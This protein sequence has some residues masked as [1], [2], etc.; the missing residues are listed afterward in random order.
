MEEVKVYELKKKDLTDATVIEGFPSVGL[1]SSIAGNYL[2]NALGL[3]LIGV[4][5]S[6][7][8]PAV[9][10]IR[11]SEPLNPVRIY[12]NN[13]P[14]RPEAD[15]EQV[16][17][18]V[19]EFQPPTSM[20]KPIASTMLDWIQEQKCSLL[21]SPEGLIIDRGSSDDDEMEKEKK[22]ME[23]INN[24]E[25]YGVASN[26]NARK[27]LTKYN[28]KEFQQGVISGVAGV[29]L[30][31]SKRRDFDTICILAEANPNY[32]D[33]RAAAKVIE[34]IDKI[35]IH[36]KIDVKPLYEEAKNIEVQLK[37]MHKQV[38]S[39][40]RSVEPQMYT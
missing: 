16:V 32:P 36:T 29:L 15:P 4:L 31:E 2:I 5:D 30:N 8:F 17:V 3:E 13:P 6:P 35:L 26:K 19:S 1:V 33:A 40:T 34:I 37:N 18:F 24:M 9:S 11:S 14:S 10:V 28:I 27:I 23:R 39:Q 12:A 22:M 25:V 21:V 38:K 20:V 7:D